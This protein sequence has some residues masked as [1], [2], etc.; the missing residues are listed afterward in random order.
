MPGNCRAV[1]ESK[2]E[3]ERSSNC[4]HL[5]VAGNLFGKV[6]LLGMGDMRVGESRLKEKGVCVGGLYVFEIKKGRFTISHSHQIFCKS[7]DSGFGDAGGVCSGTL[8]N[9]T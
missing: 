9:S 8:L 6:R 3:R 7:V 5:I 2:S 4:K 1:R